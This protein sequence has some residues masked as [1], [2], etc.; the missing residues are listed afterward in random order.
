MAIIALEGMRFY[1][2]HGFYEEEQI[3][4]NSYVLDVYVDADISKAA[5][6]DELYEPAEEDAEE[7]EQPLSVN[8]ETIYLLCKKEMQ[9]QSKLL[10]SVAQRI[11]DRIDGYFDHI[12]G[13]KVRLKKLAPPLPGKVECSY[14][15]VTTGVFRLPSGASL[16]KLLHL[17]KDWK[18]L[19]NLD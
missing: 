8:Y 4:G 7:D 16:K 15:E 5:M 9:L 19:K 3:V 17:V 12:R 18:E 10:E 1:A 13:V 11:A 2:Y 6:A 14:V